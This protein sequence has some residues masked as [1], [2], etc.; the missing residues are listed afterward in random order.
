MHTNTYIHTHARTH[1]SEV[2]DPSKLQDWGHA[3]EEGADD[4][5]VKGGG[6]VHLRMKIVH[7]KM[8]IVRRKIKI[9]RRNMEIV[10]LKI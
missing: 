5:P 6:I 2:V 1:L 8:K 9:A 7:L 3:V 10:Y 4:E